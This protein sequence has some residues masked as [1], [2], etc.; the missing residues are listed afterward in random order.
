MYKNTKFNFNY[1][2]L[3]TRLHSAPSVL[4][5]DQLSGPKIAILQF[6]DE[7]TSAG[8]GLG[9]P[10]VATR[11]QLFSGLLAAKPGRFNKN[12]GECTQPHT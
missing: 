2:C 10:L 11:E 7:N 8:H 9:L 1:L 6:L 12:V 4:C 3:K 5:S